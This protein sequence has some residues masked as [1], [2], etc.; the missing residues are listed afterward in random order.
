MLFFYTDV[1]KHA[2][3]VIVLLLC[4]VAWNWYP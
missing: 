4:K 3:V 2:D 1:V